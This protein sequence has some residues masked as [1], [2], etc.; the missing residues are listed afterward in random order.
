MIQDPGGPRFL[1]VHDKRHR[2]WTFVTGGCHHREV[3]NPIRTA[4]RELE[5]ETRGVIVLRRGTY[6]YFNF[7]ALNSKYHVF[8]FQVSLD[9]QY[10]VDRFNYEKWKMDTKQVCFRT[11]YDENDSMKFL[12]LDEIKVC[13]ELWDFIS[14]NII[15]NQEFHDLLASETHHKFSIEIA[16][17]KKQARSAGSAPGNG[18]FVRGYRPG[19]ENSGR[20]SQAGGSEGAQ[21]A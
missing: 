17:D 6:K 7:E 10:V 18:G 20:A 12:R 15:Q 19:V 11:I 14:E 13:P 9:A 21:G 16:N 8:I 3:I 1:L 2:E 4:I 5:E